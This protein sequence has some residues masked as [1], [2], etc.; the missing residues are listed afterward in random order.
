[1][2]LGRVAESLNRRGAGFGRNAEPPRHRDSARFGQPRTRGR[3]PAAPESARRGTSESQGGWPGEGCGRPGGRP[4]PRGAWA[5]SAGRLRIRVWDSRSLAALTRA[6]AGRPT[7]TA[8]RASGGAVTRRAARNGGSFPTPTDSDAR[9]PCVRV[10]PINQSN[11]PAG[12][13]A[14]AL[15]RACT[16]SPLAGDR[17]ARRWG[18]GRQAGSQ[19]WQLAWDGAGQ[20]TRGWRRFLARLCQGFPAARERAW[21]S[22]TPRDGPPGG[23]FKFRL[24]LLQRA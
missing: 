18:G 17:A 22:G 8:P 9:P 1:M 14:A 11:G 24:G 19:H 13:A 21:F 20:G 3:R 6:G 2:L 23:Q 4:R 16:G 10:S 5:S 7:V 12:A 15:L